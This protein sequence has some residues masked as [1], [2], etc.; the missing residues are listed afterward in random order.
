MAG[1]Q[2]ASHGSPENRPAKVAFRGPSRHPQ[3]QQQEQQQQQQQQTVTNHLSPNTTAAYDRR[4]RNQATS[5]STGFP[6]LLPA[7]RATTRTVLRG[8]GQPSMDA[9]AP[10]PYILPWSIGEAFFACGLSAVLEFY[11][12]SPRTRASQSQPTH[13]VHQ[14]QECPRSTLLFGF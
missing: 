2:F 4:V 9:C 12:L 6:P 1:A 14:P 13:G 7:P 5:V 11:P 10:C 8:D 3:P